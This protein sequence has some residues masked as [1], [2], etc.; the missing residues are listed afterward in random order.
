MGFDQEK[1]TK[2]REE[3]SGEKNQTAF[4]EN[5][6]LSKEDLNRLEKSL[7]ERKQQRKEAEKEEKP[8]TECFPKVVLASASPRRQELIQLLG[9]QAEIHPSGIKED[10]EEEDPSLL[11]QKLAFQKAEDVAKQYPKDYLVIGADTVVFQDKKILGKPRTEEEAYT[12]LSALSGRTHQVYTGV[13]LHF[14]GK[15]MGFYEKT[16]V[17][18][19]RLTEREIWDYIESK[20]PMDKAGAYG[21][22]GRFA[23]FIKG[24]VGD[25]YNV[26][27]LPLARLYQALK[28]L[29]AEG[30]A[31]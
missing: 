7:E 27:G 18:F 3:D 4:W 19:A 6:G 14:Q 28:F 13:S 25:Y 20:E 11:V 22:Q 17:Q 26:M 12:M 16:E 21:I 15:K 5:L 1:K 9:L 8:I 31:I 30:E 29:G 23:P 2:N 24:I 10:I